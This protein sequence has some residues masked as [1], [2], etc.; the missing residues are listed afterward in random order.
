MSNRDTVRQIM[1]GALGLEDRGA[2]H[3]EKKR[4]PAWEREAAKF[5]LTH[6]RCENPLCGTKLKIVNG[7]RNLEVHHIRKYEHFPELEM[8]QSNWVVLCRTPHD[9]HRLLGHLG[10]FGL[11]NPLVREMISVLTLLVRLAKTMA[12]IARKAE[13]P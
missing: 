12:K 2:A 3:A 4:T 7:R 6:N 5:L 10:D 13:T 1:L 11:F 9:C 8:D